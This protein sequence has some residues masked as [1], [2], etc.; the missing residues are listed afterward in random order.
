M[1][2]AT[3]V[4]WRLPSPDPESYILIAARTFDRCLKEPFASPALLGELGFVMM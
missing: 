2:T 3:S 1:T 4:A